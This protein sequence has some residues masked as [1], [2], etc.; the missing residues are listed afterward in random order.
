MALEEHLLDRVR[1]NALVLHTVWIIANHAVW[2]GPALEHVAHLLEN[3]SGIRTH[4]RR[5]GIEA[6]HAVEVHPPVHHADLV[7]SALQKLGF[8]IETNAACRVDML[9][10]DGVIAPPRRAVLRVAEDG[11]IQRL[12]GLR[13]VFGPEFLR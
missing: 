7:A 13:Q 5:G 4:A 1:H 11:E 12:V 9:N 10:A 6:V 3:H 2:Q 8:A